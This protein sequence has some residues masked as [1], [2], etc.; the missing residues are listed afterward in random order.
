MLLYLGGGAPEE[1]EE[2]E[3]DA[4][5]EEVEPE[6]AHRGRKACERFGQVRRRYYVPDRAVT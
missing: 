5:E 4:D 3:D 6:L 1:L 2:D